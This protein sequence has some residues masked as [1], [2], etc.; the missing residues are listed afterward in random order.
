MSGLVT[1]RVASTPVRTV[2]ATWKQVVD[3][4]VA[5]ESSPARVEL[6]KVRGVACAAI[7]SEATKD[8]PIV[9]HGG[10]P[11]V[12]I[13]CVFGDDAL[14][15]D[16]VDESSLVAT[17]TEGDWAM[18]IPCLAEDLIWCRGELAA[19]SSKVTARVVG[20]DVGDGGARSAAE[21]SIDIEEFRKS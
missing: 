15:G 17:P 12:R 16:G 4:L 19:I 8:C 13:Y 14:T 9:V 2:A 6:M 11:R 1:R 18:S 7:A 10:G 20:D 3:L 21:I 5:N